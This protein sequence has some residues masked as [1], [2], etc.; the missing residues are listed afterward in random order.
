MEFNKKVISWFLSAAFSIILVNLGLAIIKQNIIIAIATISIGFILL[1]FTYYS[2]QIKINEK[3]IKDVE[4][5]IDSQEEI[6][7]TLKEI[8]ILKKV[9]KIK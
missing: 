1:Y 7:N 2:P 8:L 6:L 3:R 5:R 4:E 9:G